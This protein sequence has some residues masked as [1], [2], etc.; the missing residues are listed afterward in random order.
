[1]SCCLLTG[2]VTVKLVE[3]PGGNMRVTGYMPDDN[4]PSGAL[5]SAHHVEGT[6]WAS[7]QEMPHQRLGVRLNLAQN[8]FTNPLCMTLP[9][10]KFENMSSSFC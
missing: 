1:M 5:F 6:S 7:Q 3:A 9:T 10:S 2:A 8:P 4:K